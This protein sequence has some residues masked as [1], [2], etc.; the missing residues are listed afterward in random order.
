MPHRKV[1]P[2]QRETQ[3][4][5]LQGTIWTAK[6]KTETHLLILERSVL[7]EIGR[8]LELNGKASVSS[9]MLHRR[10]RK[11]SLWTVKRDP[12]A[13]SQEAQPG[14][15]KR[16]RET[17]PPITDT[18]DDPV[19]PRTLSLQKRNQAKE[20]NAV[21]DDSPC[22]KGCKDGQ[23]KS[24][25]TS[26]RLGSA[27]NDGSGIENV[28]DSPENTDVETDG[29]AKTVTQVKENKG[30]VS[31]TNRAKRT[32]RPKRNLSAS[33]VKLTK[34]R[35]GRKTSVQLK[36]CLIPAIRQV[37]QT[38]PKLTSTNVFNVPDYVPSAL[39]HKKET[40]TKTEAENW[41]G[42]NLKRKQQKHKKT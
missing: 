2:Q 36:G 10:Q 39:D 12:T 37:C 32:V 3:R 34:M 18:H 38:S 8:L 24:E 26:N 31:R 6:S 15:S 7:P 29:I 5:A 27:V 20:G 14:K 35:L 25:Q 9:E 41:K 33:H 22:V 19:R 30:S 16:N 4:I 28:C 13:L 40:E 21:K 23:S 42:Q 11:H 17:P 1:S